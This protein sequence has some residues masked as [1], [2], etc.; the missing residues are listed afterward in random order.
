[1]R[2]NGA[3]LWGGHRLLAAARFYCR[4]PTGLSDAA[5][6]SCL[7]PGVRSRNR[8]PRALQ[9]SLRAA[10]TWPHTLPGA[11]RRHLWSPTC[12]PWNSLPASAMPL[13]RTLSM[14]SLPGLE[15]WEDEF[16]L[17]NTVLFEVAWEVA[18][19]GEH[20][21][22]RDRHEEGSLGVG[23]GDS[24]LDKG[25]GLHRLTPGFWARSL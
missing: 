15:E 16:D 2:T 21:R 25:T 8:K 6:A 18:N 7:G 9:A 23:N 11:F 10:A 14:S 17:E 5:A 20:T 13:N 4:G 1:M 12:G 24:S 19:K 22:R 3:S